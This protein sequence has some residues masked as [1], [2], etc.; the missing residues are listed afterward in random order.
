MAFVDASSGQVVLTLVYDGPARAGKTTSLTYLAHELGQPISKWED[1]EGRTLFCDWV[2]YEGGKYGGRTIRCRLLTVP[3]QLRWFARRDKLLTLADAVIFVANSSRA[4][5]KETLLSFELLQTVLF[6]LEMPPPIIVQANKQDDPDAV[7]VQ[8]LQELMNRDLAG[9]LRICATTARAGKGIRE[10]FVFAVGLALER[11]KLLD[12]Q[13]RLPTL[14][15]E[16]S[17]LE[18]LQSIFAGT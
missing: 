9:P 15:D 17:G 10:V 13:G 11:L 3:G 18:S 2:R 16:L 8:E 4:Q 6:D 1:D 12:Q 5:I 7:S 14:E